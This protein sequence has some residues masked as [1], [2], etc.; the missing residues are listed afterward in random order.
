MFRPTQIDLPAAI[1]LV[2]KRLGLAPNEH[3]TVRDAIREGELP[4][5]IEVDG[6]WA[7][8]AAGW[9]ASTDVWWPNRLVQTQPRK[10]QPSCYEIMVRTADIDKLW[11]DHSAVRRTGGPKTRYDWEGA[12]LEL[13]RLDF[14]EG[15][16]NKSQAELVAHL[17]QWF[18]DKT[19]VTPGDS[20]LKLRVKRFQETLGPLT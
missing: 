14:A 2:R 12:I 16:A 11:P 5:L 15:T 10:G 9:L 7:V 19:G 1:D 3:D 20:E 6:A 18:I 17:S 8:Q 4:L 13:T